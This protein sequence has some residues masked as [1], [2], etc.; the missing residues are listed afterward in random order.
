MRRGLDG[1]CAGHRGAGL[2]TKRMSDGVG[3][4]WRRSRSPA[5]LGVNSRANRQPIDAS[6]GVASP[7][8]TLTLPGGACRGRTAEQNCR[9]EQCGHCTG[10]SLDRRSGRPGVSAKARS[11]CVH[12]TGTESLAVGQPKIRSHNFHAGIGSHPDAADR[13]GRHH[14]PPW[15]Q[16][17][18]QIGSDHPCVLH[19]VGVSVPG[20][21]A[22][23]RTGSHSCCVSERS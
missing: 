3:R 9:G 23:K 5:A 13:P 4:S 22:P 14:A 20:L 6:N 10:E 19:P 8:E 12:R 7:I 2:E 16:A 11:R 1:C 18:G 15:A 17:R 21:D